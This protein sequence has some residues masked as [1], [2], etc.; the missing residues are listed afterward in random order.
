MVPSAFGLMVLLH[1][2]RL[3][4]KRARQ[5]LSTSGPLLISPF[6]HLREFLYKLNFI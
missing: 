1:P 5:D 4:L 3:D 2:Y 6:S